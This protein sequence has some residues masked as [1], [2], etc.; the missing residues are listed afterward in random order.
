MTQT[1][2]EAAALGAELTLHH[3]I[4]N[5]LAAVKT[6]ILDA[7]DR[8]MGRT[9][10]YTVLRIE[11]GGKTFIKIV[12]KHGGQDSVWAFVAVAN[13]ESKGMGKYNRGDIFKPATW[14]APAKHARGNVFESLP[15]CNVTTWTGPNYL[16][17]S[18]TGL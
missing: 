8:E 14:R 10:P 16:K 11:P 3:A 12:S 6:E 17:T 1:I 7:H 13:G 5:W 2:D 9:E 15:L 4:N 18:R